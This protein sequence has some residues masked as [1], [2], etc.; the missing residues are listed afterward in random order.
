MPDGGSEESIALFRA[1]G[2]LD[3]TLLLHGNAI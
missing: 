1:F 3:A 2:D